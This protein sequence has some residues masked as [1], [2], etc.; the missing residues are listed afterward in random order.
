MQTMYS[1][2]ESNLNMEVWKL[3]DQVDQMKNNLTAFFN[4]LGNKTQQV[5]SAIKGVCLQWMHHTFHFRAGV[6]RQQL[7]ACLR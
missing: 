1:H 7:S 3:R 5:I 4:L 6:Y 2:T